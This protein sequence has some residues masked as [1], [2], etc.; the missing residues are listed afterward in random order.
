MCS[1]RLWVKSAS[2][3]VVYSAAAARWA[4]QWLSAP[5]ARAYAHVRDSTRARLR[6]H[7]EH[8]LHA[9][10]VRSAC[11]CARTFRVISPIYSWFCICRANAALGKW[12][13]TSRLLRS[14]S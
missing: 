6:T 8:M 13:W 7:W 12:S 3:E 14:C 2:L 9:H 5:W 1:R 10:P 11:V 4:Q